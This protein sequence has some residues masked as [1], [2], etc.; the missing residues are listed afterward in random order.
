MAAVTTDAQ[1]NAWIQAVLTQ[2]PLG[3]NAVTIIRQAPNYVVTSTAAPGLSGTGASALAA[4]Q[5]FQTA[6]T[7]ALG[8]QNTALS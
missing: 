6:W 3:A 7:A 4:V 1:S 8:A 5:A 2:F